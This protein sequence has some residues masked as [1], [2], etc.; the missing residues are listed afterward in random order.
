MII[1]T[2]GEGWDAVFVNNRWK[3]VPDKPLFYLCGCL[4]EDD[5]VAFGIGNELNGWISPSEGMLSF[6][7]ND[8][9]IMYFNNWGKLQLKITRLS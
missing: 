3:R 9:P 7:A 5:G 8:Y 4:D 6:F 2:Y 1:P